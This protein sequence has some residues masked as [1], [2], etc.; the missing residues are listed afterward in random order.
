MIEVE[1]SF[2]KFRLKLEFWVLVYSKTF[3][4]HSIKAKRNRL[5]FN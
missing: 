5:E 1:R 4:L 2:F 3:E